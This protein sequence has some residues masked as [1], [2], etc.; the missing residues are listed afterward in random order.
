V[1]NVKAI[2][3]DFD[4][5]ILENAHVKTDAFV[6]LFAEYGPEAQAKVKAHHLEN[7]GISRFKK[8]EWIYA[9]VLGRPISDEESHALGE[10]F[11]ALALEKVLAAP[12][13]HGARESLQALAGTPSF[14]VSGTPQA[15]L[16][17]I[18]ERRELR[19]SFR[20]VHGSPREKPEILGD[21]MS[22][23]GLARTELLFVG[24]GM[25]DYHA[26]V[27]AG[28]PFLARDTPDLHDQW[29]A[30]GVPLTPDL[31]GLTEIV[32]AWGHG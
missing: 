3:F 17:L 6:E 31:R 5:V 23:H 8:F 18:V 7:L 28:V 27:A 11:S 14:V 32:R 9:N 19:P 24:D 15:E 25:S 16:E 26:A 22:R 12:F 21:L 30:L 13:V 2:A 20:E 4:G 10:R 29:K 1:G